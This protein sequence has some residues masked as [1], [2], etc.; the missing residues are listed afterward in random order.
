MTT[1]LIEAPGAQAALSAPLQQLARQ[2][3]EAR[4]RSGESLLEMARYLTAAREQAEHGEWRL[5]LDGTGTTADTAERLLNIHRTAERDAGFRA[6]VAR[7]W[8]GQTAAALLAAP[9]TPDEV[10]AEVLAPIASAPPDAP[11]P[12]AP[13]SRQIAEKVQAA[14]PPPAAAKSAALRN[15]E[16]AAPVALTPLTPAAQPAQLQM[17]P[18][19]PREP[20]RLTPLIPEVP[21]APAAGVEVIAAAG[22]DPLRLK[23]SEALIALLEQALALA[24]VERDRLRREFGGNAPRF[25]LPDES[26]EAAARSF[27]NAPSVRS[28]ASFLGMSATVEEAP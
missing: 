8:L 23:D 12:P 27:L 9:S 7:N 6:A 18:A 26:V 11:P 28:A 15:P 20:V 21:A 14:K 1:E 25:T 5:W 22:P 2:F 13:S 4:K 19:T 17:L 10:R 16:P 24:E 3:V